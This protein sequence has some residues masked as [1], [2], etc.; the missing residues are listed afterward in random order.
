[1]P[2]PFI[3]RVRL[4]NYKSIGYCDVELQALT[5]LVGPNGSGKSNFLDAIRF[6]ADGLRN[7]LDY[8]MRERGRVYRAGQSFGRPQSFSIRLDF[9][10]SETLSGFY[11]FEVGDRPNGGYAVEEEQCS[12]RSAGH[13]HGYRVRAGNVEAITAA[14]TPPAASDR[15]Y[16]VNAAGL[17]EF[18]PAYDALCQLAI[19]DFDLYRI[20]TSQ[21]ASSGDI[22]LTDGGNLANVFAR[23]LRS[24]P[25]AAERVR[26]YL[27]IIV[28]G[29]TDLRT[30][31]PTSGP[32]LIFEQ[33]IDGKNGTNPFDS[34]STSNGTLHAL[35]VLVAL[36]QFGLTPSPT[37]R[38]IGLEEPESALHPAAA[39][40][41]FE[42]IQG[43]SERLQ[44]IITS[45]S[46]ELLEDKSL[47][48]ESI[49]AVVSEGGET[50][51]API[52]ETSRDMLRDRLVTAGE[53]LRI[54]HLTPDPRTLE[55][56]RTEQRSFF[57]APSE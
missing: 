43:A 17:P 49:L 5:F 50:Q 16:L 35:G 34:F 15:L 2:P 28:P 26:Q 3:T 47:P 4:K 39:G 12:L 53:L 22:L 54:G 13:Y 48:V 57:E 9:Q 41:L 27:S 44:V 51:I 52:D 30:V 46:P 25:E 18:R 37:H 21:P 38:L 32:K 24:S 36:F 8:S 55:R 7:S 33:V 56:G 19:Y 10:V 23:M 6:V 40:I 29:L 45:H 20:R 31:E 42:A 11:S 1:M 14:I